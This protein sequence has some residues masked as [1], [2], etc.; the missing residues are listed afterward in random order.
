M[1]RCLVV[2][3]FFA[4]SSFAYGDLILWTPSGQSAH[5]VLP[6]SHSPE[7]Y[8]KSLQ[9]HPSLAGFIKEMKFTSADKVRLIKASP[10]SAAERS[11]LLANDS[12]DHALRHPRVDTFGIHFAETYILPVGAHLLLR[13]HEKKQ[14]F[15]QLTLH[16]KLLIAM[17]GHDIHPALYNEKITH[18]YLKDLNIERDQL[19]AE[20]IRYFYQHSKNF[21][22]GVCRGSQLTSAIFGARLIQDNAK[23]LHTTLEHRNGSVHPIELVPTPQ[24]IMASIM[25]G[26]NTHIVNSYHHQSVDRFSLVGTPLRLA[27]IGP[28]GIVEALELYEGNDVRGLLI[29]SHPEK[30]VPTRDIPSLFFKEI[31]NWAGISTTKTCRSVMSSASKGGAIK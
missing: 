25:K 1:G 12:E 14:F 4:L 8:L 5:Y 17:G 26:A 3:L 21:I 30:P 13:P 2:W 11:L 23:V 16:F 27:A 24:N 10:S 15:E 29:Q 31:K 28:D 6:E 22:L 7:S 19:E 18:S 9:Q 20:V